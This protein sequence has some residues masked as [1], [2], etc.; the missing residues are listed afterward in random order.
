MSDNQASP[1]QSRLRMGFIGIVTTLVYLWLAVL[2]CGGL[3]A[4]FGH[5]A[6]SVLAVASM[7][8]A[9]TAFFSEAILAPVNVRTVLIAGS[10]YL[11]S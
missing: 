11:S 10:Y 8:M 4:F 9:S 5:P 2:G 6:R 1:K 7:V 3:A